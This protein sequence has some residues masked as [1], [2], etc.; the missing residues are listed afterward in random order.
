VSRK[1]C[2]RLHRQQYGCN[3]GHAKTLHVTTSE[4]I[5]CSATTSRAIRAA[6][7]CPALCRRS[8]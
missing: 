8:L 3:A 5:P 1:R 7:R 6:V 4:P 2:A